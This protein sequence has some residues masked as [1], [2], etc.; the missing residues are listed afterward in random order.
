MSKP[1]SELTV[2]ED[3]L[4]DVERLRLP[5]NQFCEVLARFDAAF[6][7]PRSKRKPNGK[8]AADELEGE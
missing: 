2:F 4:R 5:V 1:T 7:A 8:S 3:F 6:F